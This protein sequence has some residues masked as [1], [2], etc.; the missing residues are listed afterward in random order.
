[1]LDSEWWVESCDGYNAL[2]PHVVGVEVYFSRNR[3]ALLASTFVCKQRALP[4][5][6]ARGWWW[7]EEGRTVDS[8]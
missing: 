3:R 7:W 4:P 8:C 1:M 6:A 2:M 5:H